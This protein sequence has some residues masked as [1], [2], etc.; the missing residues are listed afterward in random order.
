MLDKGQQQS[1]SQIID[2]HY[3][4]VFSIQNYANESV[5]VLLIA[6]DISQYL[7]ELATSRQDSESTKN[8]IQ[9]FIFIFSIV[10]ILAIWLVIVLVLKKVIE[11]AKQIASGD[12]VH[13]L[14]S[15]QNDEI[16]ILVNALHSMQERL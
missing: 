9:Q 5:G 16:G 7:Q 6:R 1:V 12:L 13:K 4:T 8:K 15:N 11:Q 3:V 10:T 2:N 14:E